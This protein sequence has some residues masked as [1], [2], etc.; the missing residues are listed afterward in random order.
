MQKHPII[1]QLIEA[2]LD[3][4]DQEFNQSETVQTEFMQFYQWFRKQNL[5][6]LWTSES[7]LLQVSQ[8][9]NLS[10]PFV[11]NVLAGP[12]WQLVLEELLFTF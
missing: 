8:V 10:R 6:D 4:L 2:Q 12:S 7:G 5:Q 11:I 9:G 1:E 3:F